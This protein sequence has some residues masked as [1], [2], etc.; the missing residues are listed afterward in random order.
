MSEARIANLSKIGYEAGPSNQPR[1]NG[2]GGGGYY[3]GGGRQDGYGRP[4]V[5][6]NRVQ[7]ESMMYSNG[8]RG[9]STYGQSNYP[10]AGGHS[11]STGT[12]PWANST[13]PSSENSSVERGPATQRANGENGYPAPPVPGHK[14][15]GENGYS[16][17]SVPG[18]GQYGPNGFSGP[19][20]EE[21]GAY[22]M[23]GRAPAVQP[24]PAGARRPIPLGNSGSSPALVGGGR[25]LPS[26]KQP[27]KAKRQ[28]WIKRTFSKKE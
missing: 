15:Y 13:D 7:S 28:S 19:I 3:G 4:R 16:A 18:H 26:T 22:P 24:P 17:P 5:G 8:Q 20:P 11:D 12:G 6:A 10:D 23:N 2:N 14:S 25:S 9:H 21:G 1:T 27:E